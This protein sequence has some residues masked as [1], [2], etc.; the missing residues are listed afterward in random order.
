M[1]FH[2]IRI[3]KGCSV[4]PSPICLHFIDQLFKKYDEV[5]FIAITWL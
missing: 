5:S 2:R 3:P 1:V 4:E